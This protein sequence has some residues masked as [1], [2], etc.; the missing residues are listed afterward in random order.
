MH[1]VGK[2]SHFNSLDI[3]LNDVL[4]VFKYNS[5]STFYFMLCRRQ[6]E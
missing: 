3:S 2:N 4:K 5:C 1:I 6:S